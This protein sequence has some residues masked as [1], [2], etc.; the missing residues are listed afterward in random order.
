MQHQV[1]NCEAKQSL[2]DL[3]AYGC[4][5]AWLLIE[6]HA[7][8]WPGKRLGLKSL[9]KSSLPLVG[10]AWKLSAFALILLSID[11][12]YIML[13]DESSNQHRKHSSLNKPYWQLGVN[14][15]REAYASFLLRTERQNA[16]HCC[17]IKGLLP[18]A[19][20]PLDGD[21]VASNLYFLLL[22]ST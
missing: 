8:V 2:T 3:R 11:C 1:Y 6:F 17:I 19:P 13:L 7:D 10:F 15:Q 18:L 21:P 14:F 9:L 16:T 20:P 5:K 12:L 22:Y 4:I